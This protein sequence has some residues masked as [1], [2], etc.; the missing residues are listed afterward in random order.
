MVANPHPLRSLAWNQLPSPLLSKPTPCPHPP[1]W[2]STIYNDDVN[3]SSL[4]DLEH[5]TSTKSTYV[6]WWK[7]W[8][9]RWI[10]KTIRNSITWTLV[11]S[12]D[13]EFRHIYPVDEK[14]HTVLTCLMSN[15]TLRGLDVWI[16]SRALS[17]TRCLNT[18]SGACKARKAR[19]NNYEI[20]Q[21]VQ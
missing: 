21:W 20:F 14:T 4:L 17:W 9:N 5:S 18:I 6:E 11:D 8:I 12:S 16:P 10:L 19:Q 15:L 2:P 13:E 7:F 1:P 3:N